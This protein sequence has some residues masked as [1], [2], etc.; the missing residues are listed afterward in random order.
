MTDLDQKKLV[1]ACRKLVAL[2]DAPEPG[3]SA[4]HVMCAKTVDELRSVLCGREIG[5]EVA[6]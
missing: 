4:W 1:A 5:P 2:V 6:P 3:L